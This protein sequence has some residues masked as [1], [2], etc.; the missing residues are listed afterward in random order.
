M[1]QLPIRSLPVS[2]APSKTLIARVRFDNGICRAR[3]RRSLTT[4]QDRLF[5]G[6]ILAGVPEKFETKRQ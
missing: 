3:S 4:D 5:N 2:L 6:L 1:K